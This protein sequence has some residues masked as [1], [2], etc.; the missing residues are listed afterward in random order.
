VLF[1]VVISP[2]RSNYFLAFNA[3]TYRQFA[4][5]KMTVLAFLACEIDGET[6]LDSLTA[7]DDPRIFFHEIIIA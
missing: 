2:T 6:T 5:R 3:S 7:T 4:R 1:S